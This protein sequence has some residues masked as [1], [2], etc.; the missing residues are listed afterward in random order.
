M[1]ATA[2]LFKWGLVIVEVGVEDIDVVQLQP[3]Q[4]AIEALL[5]MLPADDSVGVDIRLWGCPNLG[6]NNHVLSLHFEIL[7]NLAKLGLRLA[8]IV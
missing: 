3:L 1:E 2:D 8:S 7:K 4:G 5:D 6:R